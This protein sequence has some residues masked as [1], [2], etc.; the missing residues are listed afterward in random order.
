MSVKYHG[1][2]GDYDEKRL[3]ALRQYDILD[4]FR[5]QE[6]DDLTRLAAIICNTPIAL[7]S[8]VDKDR[9]WFKSAQGLD[10]KETHRQHSFCSHAVITPDEPFVIEDSRLDD[11]FKNNPLVTGAPEVV[12]YAGIPLKSREGYGIGSFCVIDS[13][14]RHL[15][16][17]QMEALQILARQASGMLEMRRKEAELV[18]KNEILELKTAK[19]DETVAKKIAEALKKDK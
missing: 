1:L 19:L 7:I 2:T 11:R 10:A 5:E 3:K 9:Q 14:P 18:I 13:V 15:T 8:F 12:F 17:V 4:S 6:Y 16:D